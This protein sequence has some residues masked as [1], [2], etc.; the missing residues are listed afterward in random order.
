M[1][2]QAL[3]PVVRLMMAA[4]NGSSPLSD[5][6]ELQNA[7]ALL[8]GTAIH[9][10]NAYQQLHAGAFPSSSLLKAIFINTAKDL[11]TPGPDLEKDSDRL[12]SFEALK[13][14]E[15]NRFI[16]DTILQ[17]EN[18][19]IVIQIPDHTAS[20]SLTITWNDPANTLNALKA[21]VND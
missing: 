3:L 7:T 12:R 16:E 2:N 1:L 19:D 4:L 9:L 11:D 13:T 8:S 15:E 14:I 17:G 5:Q 21:L 10:Q 6:V 18:K 20:V